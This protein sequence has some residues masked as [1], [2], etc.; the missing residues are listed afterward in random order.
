MKIAAALV[1]VFGACRAPQSDS[2]PLLAADRAFAE[3]TR[4]RRLE[5]WLSAFDAHGS[6]VGE[7]FSPI[8]GHAAVRD[9]MASFF[10]DPANELW[11]EPDTARV[12]E[13]GNLGAT[14]GRWRLT[15]KR[16]DGSIEHTTVGRY[17]DVWRKLP[18]G[19]WKLLYDIGEPDAVPES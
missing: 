9:N 11:W 5:G 14:S 10:A 16:A 12:S 4:V 7:D 17:F 13:G 1:L 3:D 6:Q 2:A 15:R 8:T 18:D 19:S